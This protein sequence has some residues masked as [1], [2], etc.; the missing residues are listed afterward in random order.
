MVSSTLPTRRLVIVVRADPVICGHSVEAR[1]L[2][3]AALLRGFDDVRILT[4]PIGLLEATGLPLKPADRILEYSHG[5]TVE[6]PEPVGDYKIPDGRHLTALTGRLVELFTDGVPTVAMSLYLMPHTLAVADALTTARAT[7]LPVNVTTIAEAVGS[8]ITNVVRA[9]V[10][11]DDFGAAARLLSAYLSQDQ[12]V[13]V[14][15]YTIEAIVEAAAELD[16]RHGT[17]FAA[18]CRQR[19]GVSYPAIDTAAWTTL[20]PAETA[21]VLDARGLEPGGYVLSLSRLMPAKGIDDLIAGFAASRAAAGTRLVVVGCGPGEEQLR[22][23][24]AASPAAERIT[25]LTDVDD[26]EKPHIMAGSAA[27]VL[28]TKPLPEFVETFGITLAESM[29]AGGG[30]VITTDVGGTLEAVGDT[31]LV[32]PPGDPAAIARALDAALTLTGRERAERAARARGY[33]LR[34]G[35]M[36][37]FDA[38]M[39]RAGLAVRAMSA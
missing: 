23:V 14:S 15:R 36:R 2:A 9:A 35:R 26:A 34:F 21:R 27:Y 24:A 4:W 16:I 32:V 3:E 30:P 28:A 38:L 6:R 11:A 19:V 18:A 1:N 20:D 8:D 25:F 22:A 10:A 33:A 29:L 7:G 37:V 31:A 17:R 39:T 5:I 13:A 12:C